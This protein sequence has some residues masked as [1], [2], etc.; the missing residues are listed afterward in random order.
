[1][2]RQGVAGPLPARLPSQLARSNQ[3]PALEAII[4]SIFDIFSIDAGQTAIEISDFDVREL[5]GG[6]YS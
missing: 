3:C 1:M 5:L 4:R 6:G 2:L